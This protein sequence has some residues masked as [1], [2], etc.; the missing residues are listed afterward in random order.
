MSFGV[1][2]QDVLQ[3][4]MLAVPVQCRLHGYVFPPGAY[5]RLKVSSMVSPRALLTLL[6]ESLHPR[7]P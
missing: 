7:L 5:L 1:V 3:L 6:S 4:V 2:L